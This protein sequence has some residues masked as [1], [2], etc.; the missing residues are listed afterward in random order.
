MPFCCL[1]ASQEITF[2][3]QKVDVSSIGRCWDESQLQEVTSFLMNS[4][5]ITYAIQQN[6]N[7]VA[8]LWLSVPFCGK[9]KSDKENCQ[10]CERNIM[11]QRFERFKFWLR[12]ACVSFL[13]KFVILCYIES[14]IVTCFHFLNCNITEIV[15]LM[16]HGNK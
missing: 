5:E 1:S 15:F 3:L 12:K 4:N 14:N 10:G 6:C 16:F 9:S 7:Y 11:I 2:L 13:H 8:I